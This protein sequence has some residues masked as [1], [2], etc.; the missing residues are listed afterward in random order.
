MPSSFDQLESLAYRQAGVMP[1]TKRG[2]IDDEQR[3]AID[4]YIYNGV[5][6]NPSMYAN[7]PRASKYL[8][9]TTYEDRQALAKKEI[10]QGVNPGGIWDDFNT[11][12]FGGMNEGQPDEE[13]QEDNN[14][15]QNNNREPDEESEEEPESESD[16]ESPKTEPDVEPEIN[17]A[18]ETGA[19]PGAESMANTGA[20]A[21]KGLGEAG[22]GA[23]GAA[24]G[25][26]EGTEAA[27]GAL[28][29]ATEGA[30]AVVTAAA[31]VV[32]EVGAAAIAAP[33]VSI[34]IIICIIV[35]FF[36][37]L[38]ILMAVAWNNPD[39]ATALT[40][41]TGSGGAAMVNGNIP[42][43]YYSQTAPAAWHNDPYGS[44][45]TI[46]S[47]GC[48]ITSLAMVISYWTGKQVLPPETANLAASHGWRVCGDGTAHAAMVDMP[49]L[50]GLKAVELGGGS[51]GWAK[52]KV[53]LAK[54]IPIIQLHHA[55]SIFTTS[56][57]YIVI[58]GFSGS[59]VYVND[60][61][62]SHKKFQNGVS[63]SDML[64]SMDDSWA[65]Y[66]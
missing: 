19:T 15:T 43:P 35:G 32:E 64:K 33:E 17:P 10:A 36:L 21:T 59:T 30:G 42:V 14:Q 8:K 12:G 56:G 11:G 25:L 60:P 2:Q 20:N 63:E 38:G 66:K 34:P 57:H 7:D 9:N 55:P 47:S 48:G 1:G 50:Y 58:T 44:C 5:R 39:S 3:K 52:D 6:R 37:M 49:K 40:P 13:E 65:I 18:E 31:P 41:T 16:E 61:V 45:G 4:N 54:G 53:Y 23:A 27:A 26:G 46:G 22:E 24:A 62:Y 28:G 51:A 29:A